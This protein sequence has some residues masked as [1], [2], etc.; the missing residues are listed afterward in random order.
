[1]TH[2][3]HERDPRGH[4]NENALHLRSHR[5]ITHATNKGAAKADWYHG[6]T[7]PA[8]GAKKCRT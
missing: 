5:K 6:L 4:V 8:E 1:V 2:H 7:E 3:E